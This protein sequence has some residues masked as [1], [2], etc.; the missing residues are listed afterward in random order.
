MLRA[1]AQHADGFEI[2]SGGEAVHAAAAVPG[3]PLAFGGPGKTAAEMAAA[4]RAGTTRFHVE[5]P[6][7]LQLLARAGRTIG[8]ELDILL[9]VNP[10]ALRTGA[11]SGR[12]C[13]AP[14]EAALVMGGHA[15]PVRDGRRL[16]DRCAGLLAPGPDGP[17]RLRGLHAHLASG[18]GRAGPARRRTP[19]ALLRAGL[20]R[21]ARCAGP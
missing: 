7:E 1:L 17:L 10:P 4:I 20:V 2:S 3:A 14:A 16:L 15:E 12:H 18:L 9:R 19:D 6:H 11:G 13:A 21:P 5:S 8:R